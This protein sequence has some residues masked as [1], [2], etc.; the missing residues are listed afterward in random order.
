MSKN[1]DMLIQEEDG[2]NENKKHKFNFN[3]KESTVALHAG[4]VTN[5]GD[6]HNTPIFAT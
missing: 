1:Q 3:W 2:N 6:A 4:E 5:Y